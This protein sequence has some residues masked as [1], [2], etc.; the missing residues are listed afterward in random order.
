VALGM[1]KNWGVSL[2]AG[3]QYGDVET[4][5]HTAASTYNYG[6]YTYTIPASDTK[7]KVPWIPVYIG[8]SLA[9]YF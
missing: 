5:M 1:R 3:Y 7:V 6:G 2:E 4:T 8:A 9:Y